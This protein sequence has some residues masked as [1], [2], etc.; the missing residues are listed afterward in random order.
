M[1]IKAVAEQHVADESAAWPMVCQLVGAVMIARALESKQSR[2]SL[3][4]D[5]LAQSRKAVALPTSKVSK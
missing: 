5:V 2:Q 3:L 1:Q 4:T